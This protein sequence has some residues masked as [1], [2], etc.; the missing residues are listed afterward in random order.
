M[1]LISGAEMK[2]VE[3]I[4]KQYP[5]KPYSMKPLEELSRKIRRYSRDETRAVVLR[6]A[7]DFLRLRRDLRNAEHLS[8]CMERVNLVM[9]KQTGEL[10][11]LSNSLKEFVLPAAP[12]PAE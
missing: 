6:F 11:R 7:E 5:E 8:A 9:S 2:R 4:L 3:D 10:S 1:T 12:R